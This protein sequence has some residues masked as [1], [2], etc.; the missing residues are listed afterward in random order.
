MD[1]NIKKINKVKKMEI[2]CLPTPL[3]RLKNIERELNFSEIYIKRD[4]LTGIGPG[5]NKIR[6]LEY[7]LQDA[8]DKNCDVVLVSG[9]EQS[10]LC[11]VTSCV[12]RKINLECICV[13]NCDKPTEI[14]GNNILDELVSSVSH[15]IGKVNEED[16]RKYVGE[17]SDN[18]IDE[19]KSPYIIEN[20]ASTGLGAMG[21]VNA[22]IELQKQCNDLNIKIDEIFA[23]GANGGVAAGLIYG[24]AVLGRPFNINIIS[25]EYENS[26]LRRNII[27]I[28]KEIEK[29]TELPFD[30]KLEEVCNL[31]DS[32][33]G[34][35]WGH[36]T[37]ESERT[38]FDFPQKEGIFVENIYTSKVL[39]GMIDLIK[40]KQ[41]KGNACFIHTG[42]FAS[43]FGQF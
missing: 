7:I 36:N 41:V 1:T 37:K 2:G 13:Y 34:Y 6:S 38:V 35:G 12:C 11:T 15:Y 24:N 4:D 20:G 27:R 16:R 9:P 43:L 8:V 21:Y 30:Y 5:G 29:I 17:L 39:T 22:I 18:L 3:H 23:P 19:G 25:V 14:K 10:N 32:Y 33:K 28:I 31:I 26:I 40:N 42:G